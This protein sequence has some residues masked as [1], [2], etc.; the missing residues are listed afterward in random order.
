MQEEEKEA[1]RL[2]MDLIESRYKEAYKVK[3]SIGDS[4]K[5]VTISMG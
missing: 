5:E 2:A 4:L 1:D 3:E